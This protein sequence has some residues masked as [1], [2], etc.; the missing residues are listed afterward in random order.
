MMKEKPTKLEIGQYAFNR[1][2]DVWFYKSVPEGMRPAE[3]SDIVLGRMVLYK[4][5][6]GPDAGSYYTSV[7]TANNQWVFLYDV[8]HSWPVYVKN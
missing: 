3:S 8:T 4:V 5:R 6:I 7:I 1:H 2:Y